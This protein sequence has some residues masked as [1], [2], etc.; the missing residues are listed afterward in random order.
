MN[1]MPQPL[2]PLQGGFQK[3]VGCTTT[4][5][6]LQESINYAKENHSKIYVCFLDVKQAFDYVW[7]DGLFLKLHELGIELYLWKSL[8]NLYEDLTSYVRFRGFNICQGTRQGGVTSPLMFLCFVNDLL[9]IL[10]NS[11]YGLS[12][13]GINVTCPTV[14][15]DMVLTSLTRRCLQEL[16][17]IC[18]RYSR[19]RRFLYN[20]LKCAVIVFNELVSSYLCSRRRWTLGSSEVVEKFSYLHLGVE[21]DTHMKTLDVVKEADSKARR[22]FFSILVR[23]L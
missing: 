13:S 4:S 12:I 21:C 10:C 6:V 11:G 14:A 18:Y 23:T 5:F 8:V 2:N 22:T 20:A 1:S 15:D 16:M 7:H 17:N 3:N 19:L 9:N